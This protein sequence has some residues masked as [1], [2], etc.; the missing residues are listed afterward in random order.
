MASTNRNDGVEV[1]RRRSTGP[2]GRGDEGVLPSGR[3]P[4]RAGPFPVDGDHGVEQGDR[5]HRQAVGDQGSGEGAQGLGDQRHVVAATDVVDDQVGMVGQAHVRIVS[6]HVS[7]PHREDVGAEVQDVVPV[8]AGS[9][10]VTRRP[11]GQHERVVAELTRVGWGGSAAPRAQ[12]QQH[13]LQRLSEGGQGHTPRHVLAGP[14]GA[15]PRCRGPPGRRAAM[16][17][18]WR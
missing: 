17:A 9:V 15:V 18:R 13:R 3:F 7:G 12:C 4:P 10:R 8:R 11:Q 2:T 5:R 14:G 1:E 16:T 6:G